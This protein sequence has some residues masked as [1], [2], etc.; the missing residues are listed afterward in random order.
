MQLRSLSFQKSF[1]HYIGKITVLLL[2]LSWFA[3]PNIVNAD[4]CDGNEEC[5]FEASCDLD[6][7]G[8]SVLAVNWTVSM[9]P[10]TTDYDDTRGTVSLS[11]SNGGSETISSGFGDGQASGSTSIDKDNLVPANYTISLEGSIAAYGGM[12]SD[13]CGDS[14]EFSVYAPDEPIY[15]CMDEDANN[16]NEEASIDDDSC[17]YDV[18]GCM[19]DSYDNYDPLATID[20]GSCANDPVGP[21]DFSIYNTACFNWPNPEVESN[22]TESSGATTYYWQKWN[23]SSYQTIASG[24]IGQVDSS[25]DSDVTSGVTYYYRMIAEN[26]SGSTVSNESSILVNAA[27]CGGIQATL[28]VSVVGGGTVTGGGINCPGTCSYM[29]DYAQWVSITGTPTAGYGAVVWTGAC[30]GQPATCSLYMDGNKNTTGTFSVNTYTLTVAKAGTGSGTVI[31]NPAGINCGSDCSESYAYNTPVTL[32]HAAAAGSVFTN[33]SGDCSGSGGCTVTMSAA[34]SVT[35]TF[36]ADPFNYSLSNSGTS[37]A[38]KGSGDVYTQNTITKTLSAGAT[39]A[40]TLALSGVPSGVSYSISNSS[41]SP[42]CT[43]VITFT[44]TTAAVAGNHTI[45]VTGSP[46]SKTTAFTLSITGASFSV[47]CSRN[48]STALLGQSIL[49]SSSVTG[50]RAPLTYLWSGSNA[51]TPAPTTSTWSKSYSTVGQ[52]TAQVT[53]T[54]ADSVQATCTPA[55]AQINFDPSF[56]EF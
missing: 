42:T 23:G 7:T 54:D 39:Q 46:L 6:I 34:K 2:I 20:D 26:A 12:Y 53:V 51:P 29:Y 17:T 22:F 38:T 28:T 11:S 41:C 44:V 33:W 15:G 32:T 9:S 52:K 18:Y 55:T 45:T 31:S 35:A 56:K 19:D 48:P 27:N 4:G 16:F 21:G 37:S 30:A 14:Y 10:R 43:S 3:T 1:F 8:G 36:T 13:S 40:V 25:T 49:W 5:N 50:G 47:T 24:S